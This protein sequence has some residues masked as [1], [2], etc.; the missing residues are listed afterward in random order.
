MA[1]GPF[2]PRKRGFFC[3]VRS[4][5]AWGAQT[6]RI[7]FF[8]LRRAMARSLLN[9]YGA[10]YELERSLFSGWTQTVEDSFSMRNPLA[11]YA[12]SVT[13]TLAL[14]ALVTGFVPGGSNQSLEPVTGATS[15]AKGENPLPR[16]LLHIPEQFREAMKQNLPS[17]PFAAS[18][19]RFPVLEVQ[20]DGTVTMRPLHGSIPVKLETT[21]TSLAA[22]LTAAPTEPQQAD[23]VPRAELFSNMPRINQAE[24][25]HLDVL[26][27]QLDFDDLPLRWNGSQQAFELAPEVLE[28]TEKLLGD[29]RQLSGL[30]ASMRRQA[31]QYRPVVEKYADRYNLSP[32]LVFAII[33]TESDFDPDLISNRSAH[34][35][36]QVVPDTAGGE[37]HRWL[38][39]TGKPSPSLLLHPETNIKYGT[40]YMYLLQNRHLSA[41]ADPQSREYC[42]IAAY[43]IGTGGMLRTF[44]KS[45]DAAFEAINAMT[46]EQVRNTLLKK[47]SSR[48]TKAFLAKVLKS[49][50]RFSMLG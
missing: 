19:D 41:I 7:R 43:N 25:A 26:G 46:P 12:V 50:E 39:R 22:M 40:A 2:S 31:E 35:L 9:P 23:F 48:E 33:Y 4:W 37:V 34:G 21:S 42:A 45:R 49:R 3:G 15:R 29:L 16:P 1:S 10:P 28:R 47:L 30:T 13:G 5:A 27:K 11:G 14:L 38:G 32:D 24:P 17:T 44:G 8:Y 18:G 20:S 6:L 36:M